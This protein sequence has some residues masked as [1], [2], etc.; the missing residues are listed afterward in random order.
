VIRLSCAK[1]LGRQEGMAMDCR[2]P[3]AHEARW[4]PASPNNV[5]VGGKMSGERRGF[6][7]AR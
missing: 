2:D 4:D 3:E 7:A 5:R 6:L 1:R